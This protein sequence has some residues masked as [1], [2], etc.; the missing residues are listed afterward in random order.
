M[1]AA[2]MSLNRIKTADRGSWHARPR[3]ANWLAIGAIVALHVGGLFGLMQIDAVRESVLEA[4]PIFVSFMAAPP[5]PKPAPPMPKPQ[6]VKPTPAPRLIAHES[7]APAAVQAAK[8][9]EPKQPPPPPQAPAEAAPPAPP[10]V[11][12]PNFVAGYLDNPAPTYPPVSRN[13]GEH[14]RVLLRVYVSP[15]GHSEQI[16]VDRSSGFDRLDRSAI[17]AVRRW[18][19][20]PAKQGSQAV[21]AWVL[22]PIN[23][24]LSQ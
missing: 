8:P 17:E 2:T 13:L 24:N 10:A 23:F 19:F 11:T 12:P 4:A 1:A 6:V 22:I 15:E 20:V 7:P 5:A 14:G 3:R 18:R 9:D 16:E 21:A